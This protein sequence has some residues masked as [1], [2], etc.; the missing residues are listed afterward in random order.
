MN[1]INKMM[2]V[3]GALLVISAGKII[4]TFIQNEAHFNLSYTVY[5]GAA[6]LVVYIALGL[7]ARYL[8]KRYGRPSKHVM[9]ANID[10]KDRMEKGRAG[11]RKFK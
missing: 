9:Y 2:F 1:I 11:S 3:V 10:Q 4:V 5:E 8:I 7:R 6:F